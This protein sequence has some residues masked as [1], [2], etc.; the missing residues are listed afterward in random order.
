MAL[1]NATDSRVALCILPNAMNG[2]AKPM[3]MGL[4]GVV[5]LGVI[6]CYVTA[7]V[8]VR[9]RKVEHG[10]ATAISV[11]YRRLLASLTVVAAVYVFSTIFPVLFTI[12]FKL[13]IHLDP[14]TFQQYAIYSTWTILI[15]TSCAPFVYYMR[16]R[17]YRTAFQKVI[18]GKKD[19]VVS[20]VLSQANNART[21]MGVT[22]CQPTLGPTTTVFAKKLSIKNDTGRKLTSTDIVFLPSDKN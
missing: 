10:A 20:I 9:K 6:A 1:M 15:Q 5:C 12:I 2:F 11:E 14:V 8:L 18:C 17:D 4:N 13:I 21:S 7:G 3:W 19:T 22:A 16:S